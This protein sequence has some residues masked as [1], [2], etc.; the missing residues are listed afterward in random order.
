[1]VEQKENGYYGLVKAGEFVTR[2]SAPEVY[3]M[4]ASFYFYR[5]IYFDRKET[6]VIN[7]CSLI[8]IMPH[9]CFDLDHPIDFDFMEY[10]LVNNKLGFE[11]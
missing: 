6:T 10:L 3:D 7:D 2:Q 8:Y 4:N 1:M 5:R 11:L 9:I